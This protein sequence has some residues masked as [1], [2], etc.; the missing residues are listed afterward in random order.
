MA[1]NTNHTFEELGILR[2]SIVEKNCTPDRLVFLQ[3]L[4]EFNDFTVVFA[5]S[6][7]PKTP[8]KPV[9]PDGTAAETIPPPPVTYTVG[10]TDL[11]FN[12]MNAIYNRELKTPDGK[13]V[14]PATWKQLAP[15]KKES[16]WYWK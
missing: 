6:P 7:P 11:S 10:V 1:L 4:L 16:A 15:A 12:V 2:C 9:A 3:D 14:D 5:N 13:T 8:A